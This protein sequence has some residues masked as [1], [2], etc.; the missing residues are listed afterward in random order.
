MK[1]LFN[2]VNILLFLF[3]GIAFAACE[4]DLSE[5]NVGIETI[6]IPQ[7][8]SDG[9]SNND[10]AVPG[11]LNYGN[12]VNFKDDDANNKVNVFLGVSK[13]GE[14]S[15]EP[16]SVDI[17]LRPDTI[18]QLIAAGKPYL[19]LPSTAFTIPANI[20]LAAGQTNASFNMVIDKATLKTFA[21]KQVA[22]CISISNPS[23]YVL[24]PLARNVIVI[25]DVNK[26]NLK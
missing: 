10:H 17:T 13:S 6:S 5:I 23:K 20:T 18:N 26:L 25:I 1:I 7:A 4:K 16:F 8:F 22:A 11:T 14:Q 9:T 21:G 24:N 19:L 15:T 12:A 3:A 2:R